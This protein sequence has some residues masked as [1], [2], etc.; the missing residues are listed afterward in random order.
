L[1][2]FHVS[3]QLIVVLKITNPIAG[4]DIPFRSEVVILGGK[5]PFEVEDKSSTAELSGDKVL[6]PTLCAFN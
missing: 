2:P 5:N 3:R 1:V 4:D 6:I